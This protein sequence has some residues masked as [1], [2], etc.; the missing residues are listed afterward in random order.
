MLSTHAE[1]VCFNLKLRSVVHSLTRRDPSHPNVPKTKARSKS[2]RTTSK[3]YDTLGERH[4]EVDGLCWSARVWS[5]CAMIQASLTLFLTKCT[6]D[7]VECIIV[8]VARIAELRW[9][10]DEISMKPCIEIILLSATSAI[11]TAPLFRAVLYAIYSATYLLRR[12]AGQGLRTFLAS[13]VA[14]RMHVDG[15]FLVTAR[16]F[17]SSVSLLW[18]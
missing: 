12:V 18:I 13:A 1:L 9:Y 14:D 4:V 3:T 2:L 7:V 17:L 6:T 10:M 8:Q 5:V 15:L 11:N 16:E